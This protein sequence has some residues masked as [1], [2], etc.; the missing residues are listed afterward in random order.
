MRSKGIQI[1]KASVENAE[2]IAM[3]AIKMWTD[4]TFGELKDSFSAAI[5]DPDVA[6]F[7]LKDENE[8]VGFAQCGLRH[9]YVE[10]TNSSPV[11]YLEGIFVE[12]PYR[13]QGYAKRLL[14]CCEQWAKE[15]GCAEFAGDC[16][17]DNEISRLFH[18]GTGFREANR[19][20]CFTKKL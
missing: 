4:H 2:A 19:I 20:I 10:G 16:E 7:I 14:D 1:K 15:K 11:G 5:N 9:D 13:K 8:V 6:V 12:G 3:L 17:L 18:L